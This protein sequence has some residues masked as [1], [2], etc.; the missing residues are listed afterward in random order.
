MSSFFIALV[1]LNAFAILD[2]P[3]AGDKINLNTPVAVAMTPKESG[4]GVELPDELSSSVR[5]LVESDVASVTGISG[6]LRAFIET[7]ESPAIVTA[8]IALPGVSMALAD[9]HFITQ[10]PASH[11]KN[12]RIGPYRIGMWPHA[13]TGQGGLVRYAPPAGFIEVTSENQHTPLSESFR[14]KDFLTKGQYGVWPKYLVVDLK[15]VDKLEL[16]LQDLEGRGINTAGIRVMSGFRTPEY[17]ATGGDPRGRASLSRHM[18]GDAADIFIDNTGNGRMDDLNGDGRVDLKD[19]RV[20][21]EAAERVE[22]EYP[23]LVGGIGLY[24]ANSSHGPFV[25]I[26]VRGHAARW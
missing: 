17:N 4:S 20:I 23:S 6:R 26:D 14:L 18:Y 16:I 13:T 15:L 1:A 24:K 21:A 3:T 9:F 12:G 7:G 8:A 5:A 19:A 22:K 10:R 25:H 11:N 2:L